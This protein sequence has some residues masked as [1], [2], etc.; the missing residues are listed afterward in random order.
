MKNTQYSPLTDSAGC[1]LNLY[2][3][4]AN[5]IGICSYGVGAI[6][7]LAQGDICGFLAW[8]LFIGWIVA[9]VLGVMW[10]FTLYLLMTGEITITL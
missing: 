5:I 2:M 4:A 3:G 9:P 10:P 7:F 8:T 6:K 1:L